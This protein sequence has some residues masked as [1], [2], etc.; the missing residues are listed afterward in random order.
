MPPGGPEL[1]TVSGRTTGSFAADDEQHPLAEGREPG[2]DAPAVLLLE[3]LIEGAFE[4]DEKLGVNARDALRLDASLIAL[5]GALP[6]DA[7]VFAHH[8]V[9][10]FVPK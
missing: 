6:L 2:L 4:E 7:D 10:E 9:V 5:G 3:D 8:P 1:R